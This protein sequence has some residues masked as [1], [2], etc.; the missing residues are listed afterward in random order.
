[1][2]ENQ[3][4]SEIVLFKPLLVEVIFFFLIRMHSVMSTADFF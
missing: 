1:M 4:L 3:V 2:Q